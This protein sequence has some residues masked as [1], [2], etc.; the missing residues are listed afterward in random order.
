MLATN[1]APGCAS[2]PVSVFVDEPTG[3]GSGVPNG[4]SWPTL[5]EGVDGLAHEM[6]AHITVVVEAL[7]PEVNQPR[8]RD[9]LCFE[10]LCISVAFTEPCLRSQ[11]VTK[12][13]QPL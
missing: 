4:R 11:L 6:G 10:E 7:C 13:H 8:G 1:G 5:T 3:S 12:S 2:P 9:V